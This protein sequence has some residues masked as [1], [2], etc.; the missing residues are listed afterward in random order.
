LFETCH[1]DV[2]KT[3]FDADVFAFMTFVGI[4]MMLKGNKNDRGDLL[5]ES[6]PS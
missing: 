6:M 2:K 5:A 1:K 3:K 4:S